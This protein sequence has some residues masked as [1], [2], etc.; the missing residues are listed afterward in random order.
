MNL[1]RAFLGTLWVV[2][3]VY[4]GIVIAEHGMGLLPVFFGDM[5]KLGWPGQFNLDFTLMLTLSANWVA[6]RYEYSPAGLSLALVAFFGGAGFL[7]PYLLLASLRSGG[8]MPTL[9]LGEGR[10]A[11]CR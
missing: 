2:L 10:A 1:F 3:V 8:D 11:R 7:Y 6:W 4:T 5:A 9:L